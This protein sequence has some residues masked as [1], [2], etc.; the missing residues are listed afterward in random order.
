MLGLVDVQ[1]EFEQDRAK[2]DQLALEIV[3]FAVGAFPFVLLAETLD[4]FDHDAPVPGT[5]ENGDLAGLGQPPPE[6]PQVMVGG[7][8]AF[9][10]GDGIHH[11]TARIDFLGDAPDGSAFAGSIPAL[12]NDS[13]RTL[14]DIYLVCQFEQGYLVL[15]Q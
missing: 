5:V 3:D 15:D 9:G 8:I 7:V 2:I 11:K 4:P 6:A 1:P 14:L 13:H 10:S 12:E